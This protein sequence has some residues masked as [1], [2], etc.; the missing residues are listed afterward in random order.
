MNDFKRL[1]VMLL[2]ASA[3]F[4]TACSDNSKSNDKDKEAK[5]EEPKQ[6]NQ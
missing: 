2:V 4:L 1:L 5:G 6:E 3:L